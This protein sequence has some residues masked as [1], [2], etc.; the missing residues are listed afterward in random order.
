MLQYQAA[1]LAQE[2]YFDPTVPFERRLFAQ[3]ADQKKPTF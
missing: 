3:G 1:F 2:V